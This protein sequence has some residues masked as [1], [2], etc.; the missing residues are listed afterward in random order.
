MGSSSK[1][2][3]PR[4]LPLLGVLCEGHLQVPGEATGF[5]S[6]GPAATLNLD[7]VTDGH[8]FGTVLRARGLSWWSPAGPCGS[9]F[10]LTAAAG[11]RSVSVASSCPA[12]SQ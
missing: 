12:D 9:S 5:F 8:G 4:I 1:V 7:G 10:A 6:R 3:L 2:T 11:P